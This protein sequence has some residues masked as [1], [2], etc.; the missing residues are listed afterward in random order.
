MKVALSLLQ[1][2]FVEVRE[3]LG[4]I[5]SADDASSPSPDKSETHVSSWI[6]NRRHAY[7]YCAYLCLE[8]IAHVFRE[9][10]VCSRPQALSSRQSHLCMPPQMSRHHFIPHVNSDN[11]RQ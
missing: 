2:C 1:Y 11:H 3:R 8:G 4:E 7:H 9:D 5:D 6:I 10:V